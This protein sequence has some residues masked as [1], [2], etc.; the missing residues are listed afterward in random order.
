MILASITIR[1]LR[2]LQFLVIARALCSWFP[3][4]Q[5]SAVGEFLYT[6]TEPMLAPC[7][8]LLSSFQSGRGMML[9]FSPVIVLLLL[10]FAERLVY[11]L[12]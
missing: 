3:Q 12:L 1:I 9:D 4:V 11:A 8:S 5:R 10:E 7:R 2:I 6:V